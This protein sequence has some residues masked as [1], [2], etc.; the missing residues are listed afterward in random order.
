MMHPSP[1]LN[2]NGK[3]SQDSNH[4]G[5]Q[6]VRAATPTTT[7]P[8]SAT[9]SAFPCSNCGADHRAT[10]CGP[11]PKCYICQTTLPRAAAR[12]ANYLANHKHESKRARFGPTPTRNHYTPPT[13]PFLSR[14][15]EDMTSNQSPY[16]SGHDSSYSHASAPGNPPSSRGN[17]DID[18]QIDRYIREQR[19]ATLISDTP[20]ATTLTTLP[21]SHDTQ[22]RDRII[23]LS[24]RLL[25]ALPHLIT[26]DPVLLDSPRLH[27]RYRPLQ[28]R[29]SFQPHQSA[30]KFLRPCH[31]WCSNNLTNPACP[32]PAHRQSSPIH[33]RN[34]L[35]PWKA[36]LA[37]TTMTA[38]TNSH[39]YIPSPTMSTK[40]LPV[41]QP[42]APRN[43]VP[44]P[45]DIFFTTSV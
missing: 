37:M 24:H 34:R 18:D 7:T 30:A 45:P 16:D 8:P 15:A 4:N 21:T 12:Q 40:L 17:S 13:S 20:T 23:A 22:Q 27:T 5:T 35:P 41:D 44:S 31:L 28:P 6:D 14:S 3:R 9:K 26:H 42:F 33:R 32:E 38:T 11:D 19:V 39:H 36:T 25:A 10:E 43:L 2:Y 29:K 1:Q